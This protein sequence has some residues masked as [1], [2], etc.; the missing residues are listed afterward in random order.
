MSGAIL[1]AAVA[2]AD[3]PEVR[4][5]SV[6]QAFLT[7]LGL[8]APAGL[9]AYLP[10]LI[11]AI[12]DRFVG[13]I[14]LDRPYDL[15]SSNLGIGLL[16][17][18]LTIELVVDKIP[19]LDHLN[20]LVQSAIRPSAGAYLMMAA[21]TETGLDP[22]LALLIGL[23]GAGGVH[24]VKASA[25]PAVT[26]TTGGMGNPLVSMVED[27]IAATIAIL[28]IA[29][30]IVATVLLVIA[31]VLLLWAARWVARRARHRSATTSSP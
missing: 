22:I 6:E 4:A 20:D 30:P 31:L 16:V 8:A 7:G 18:L 5:D 28:A 9:N 12:A 19:T 11:V 10:L 1:R 14:T 24:A 23:A 13:G 29:A 15:L 2:P 3:T 17:V 21:T 27:G 25:R 26:V